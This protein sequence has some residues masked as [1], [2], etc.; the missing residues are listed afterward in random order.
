MFQTITLGVLNAS[1][2]TRMK[3]YALSFTR[4][5]ARQ[6]S[7]LLQNSTAS[8]Q[9]SNFIRS[10]DARGER[11][12][13]AA[14]GG[15]ALFVLMLHIG[16][17][18]G[19]DLSAINLWVVCA[20]LTL[21]ASSALRARLSRFKTLPERVL[22]TL[23]VV[24]VAVFL[25][26]IWSYQFAYDHPA[27]GVLK[28]PSITILFVLVALRALRFHPLPL[29]VTG[30]AA[31]IGW[32]ILLLAAI[33]IDGSESRTHD[34]VAYLTTYKILVGAEIE[35]LVAL[36]SL[37]MFLAFATHRA[38]A[39]L[40][41]L[42]DTLEHMPHG[43]AMFDSR[44]RIVVCNSLYGE[45]YNLTRD[46][47]KPG[48]SIQ[49]LVEKRQQNGIYGTDNRTK[50]FAKDWLADFEQASTR[51]QELA[52]GRILSIRRRRKPD[53][54]MITS[55]VDITD[56]KRLEARIEHMAY[57][58]GLTG[59]ANRLLLLE[60]L[61][62]M[63]TGRR[64]PD[65]LTVF[66]L[67]LDHFKEV[68]DS[69]GHQIGDALLQA[70]ADRLRDS[71]RQSDLVARTGGDE[72]VIVQAST[73]SSL[74]AAAL[75]TRLVEVVGAPYELLGHHVVIGVSVG[76]SFSEADVND[77][78]ELIKQADLALYRAKEDGRGTFRFFEE[79][80]N[81]RLQARRQMES[82][83]R[84]ALACNEFELFYQPVVGVEKDK[85]QGVEA[86]IRWHHPERGM[87]SPA[88]FIPLVEEIG[89][90]IPLGDWVIKQA[91]SD[92]ARWPDEIKVAVNVSAAQFRKAG[93][94]DTVTQALDQTGLKASRLELEITETALL[95]DCETTIRILD[96]L[97]A[98]GV[99][100]AM[101][102]FGTGYAS[103]SYLQKFPFDRI[104]IDRSFIDEVNKGG[105]ASEIVKTVISLGKRLGMSTTAE[106]VETIEQFN[107]IKAEGCSDIQG[108][109]ISQPKP[110]N[111]IE[112]MFGEL[113]D[114]TE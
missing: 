59:L 87:V 30:S 62:K 7:R 86:L 36:L 77:P 12:V 106:G 21:V 67:D 55:T 83:L 14:Q 39:G 4:D 95:E 69:L 10:Y 44:H 33:S 58:D 65:H 92:A 16:A 85:I 9:L 22:N 71:V 93:L 105:N 94:V 68:N 112:A 63:L 113:S 52:D 18:V 57:H 40:L 104:K 89:L 54:G 23:N 99:R 51:I 111:E 32:L 90:A 11:A 107:A 27:G 56:R 73:S 101:D 17:R 25:L 8:H 98:L 19:K 64:T 24:D 102:D 74:S 43:V 41:Q 29:I 37:V 31:A 97:R 20:L 84:K 2:F 80:M 88:D 114:P 38:R 100:V 28:A 78:G 75:A 53:G 26:L 45:I 79:D 61:E 81:K 13:A 3:S 108:F 96:E 46:D 70:V 6:F 103:L 109:L 1:G 66:C 34:Y 50:S 110:R 47:V 42:D 72:F 15:I 35:K 48:T 49:E 5:V 76:V 82:D 60:R 91:C